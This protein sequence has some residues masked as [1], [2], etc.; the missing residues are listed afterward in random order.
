[1]LYSFEGLS[2][3]TYTCC[4]NYIYSDIDLVCFNNLDIS[5]CHYYLHY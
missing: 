3:Y 5:F 4:I 2:I 1:M